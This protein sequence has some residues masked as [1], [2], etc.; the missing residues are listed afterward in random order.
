MSSSACCFPFCFR[1]PVN[2]NGGDFKQKLKLGGSEPA[3]DE[4]PCSSPSSSYG[5]SGVTCRTIIFPSR[6]S[7]GPLTPNS[8]FPCCTLPRKKGLDGRGSVSDINCSLDTVLGH[9]LSVS[10][11]LAAVAVV[12][13][14]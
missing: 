7:H 11:S 3:P 2:A 9:R 10:N 13:V 4:T 12:F 1:H 8:S 14:A 6:L 5:A